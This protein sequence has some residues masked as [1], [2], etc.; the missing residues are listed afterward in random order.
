MNQFEIIQKNDDLSVTLVENIFIN[1][2]MPKAPGDFVKVYLLGLKY[3]QSK[4][5]SDI[6]NKVIA[7]SLNLLE[8]DV[9]KAWRYW[10]DEGI[11]MV[12]ID[13]DN[14]IIKYFNITSLMIEGKGLPSKKDDDSKKI[15]ETRQMYQAIERMFSRPLSSKELQTIDS[16]MSDLMFDIQTVMLL[17]EYCLDKNKKDINYMN[18]VALSWYDK[19]ISTYD[20]AMGHIEKT[21]KKWTSY[22]KIMNFLGFN[23]Q[24]TKG[25]IELMD[26][27]LDEYKFSLEIIMEGCR[28]MS[29]TGKPNFRYLNSILVSWNKK[30]YQ[31]LED[32]AKEKIESDSKGKNKEE[33]AKTSKYDYDLIQKKLR[34]KMWSDKNER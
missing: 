24:P 23:R 18:R 26:R 13:Q 5:L 9:I 29:S 28:R 30:G 19:N 22:Y 4:N 33:S 17:V 11:L 21:N 20:V 6:S 7:K 1:H 34:E 8:S 12:E 32:I 10:E 3:C 14:S 27:W 15:S 31:T 25:E 16:W 2:Y